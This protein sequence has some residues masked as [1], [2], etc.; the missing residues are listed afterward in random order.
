M[1]DTEGDSTA[2]PIGTTYSTSDYAYTPD[3]LMTSERQE[4]RPDWNS[5]GF[6]VIWDHLSLRQRY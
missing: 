5:T 1:S 4:S 2:A 3:E 6:R